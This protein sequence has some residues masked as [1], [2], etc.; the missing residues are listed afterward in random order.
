MPVRLFVGN[1]PYDTTDEQL[2]EHFAEVGPLSFVHIPKDRETGR[3]RGFA[4][5][6][7]IE[8]AQAEEAIRR[9]NTQPF[10]GRPLALNQARSRDEAP[11]PRSASGAPQ[12]RS[13]PD[14]LA[15]PS[16]HDTASP[17]GET[18][19]REFGPDAPPRR[20]RK[21][22]QRDQKSDRALK[23]HK[24]ERRVRNFYSQVDPD[25][26]DGEGEGE[27]EY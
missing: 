1:I 5:I 13:R 17:Y 20:A 22:K 14:W 24:R 9:F 16:P 2:R 15:P 23:P 7:F 27:Y 3:S 25:A 21:D 11:P 19:S 4:F 12:M 18:P 8:A 10:R 6:E 26:D